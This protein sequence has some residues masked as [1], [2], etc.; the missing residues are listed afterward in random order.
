M[1]AIIDPCLH[2]CNELAKLLLKL[3]HESEIDPYHES[4]RH[5]SYNAP[6]CKKMYNREHISVTKWCIVGY[7]TCAS[8]YSWI[9]SPPYH[10]VYPMRVKLLSISGRALWKLPKYVRVIACAQWNLNINSLS[11]ALDLYDIFLC[12]KMYR[13]C[14]R[15]FIFYFD[16]AW[17]KTSTIIPGSLFYASMVRLWWWLLRPGLS[18]LLCA[19]S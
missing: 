15:T 10:A 13:F 16:V 5:I 4:H 7:G 19:F 3:R 14:S 1:N 6:I 12:F 11:F 18:Q 8:W 2:Y 17:S 9:R